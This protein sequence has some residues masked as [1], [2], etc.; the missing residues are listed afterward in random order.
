[1]HVRLVAQSRR[2]LKEAFTP[3]FFL[4]GQGVYIELTVIRQRSRRERVERRVERASSTA[5]PWRSCSAATCCGC[6]TVGSFTACAT[7]R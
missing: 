5:S 1:V 6:A 7:Q 2:E 4:P 3:D